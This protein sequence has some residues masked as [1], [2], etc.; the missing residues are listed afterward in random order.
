MN[1]KAGIIATI[2]IIV[3][4]G[5]FFLSRGSSVS[6]PSTSQTQGIQNDSDLTSASTDLDKTDLNSTDSELNQNVTDA[7]TF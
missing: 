2:I 1:T 3:V 7:S 4:A 6:N 5:V